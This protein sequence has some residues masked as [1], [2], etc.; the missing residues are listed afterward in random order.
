MITSDD[1]P[2][3]AGI[4]PVL[5]GL[6]EP[7]LVTGL[8]RTKTGDSRLHRVQIV[9][10]VL[11]KQT[12]PHV[13]GRRPHAPPPVV[14]VHGQYREP[15]RGE[16]ALDVRAPVAENAETSKPYEQLRRL[17]RRVVPWQNA[18]DLKGVRGCRAQVVGVL[19]VQQHD[20]AEF[21]RVGDEP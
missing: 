17:N 4:L 9:P 20:D 18:S 2:S 1:L 21:E 10:T 5:R 16:Q 14:I 7:G 19:G 13:Q 11:S 6:Q 8:F 12:Q 3:R 15:V